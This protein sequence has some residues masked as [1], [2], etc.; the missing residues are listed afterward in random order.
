MTIYL[1]VNLDEAE[2]NA[3]EALRVRKRLSTQQEALREVIRSGLREEQIEEF[4]IT[5]PR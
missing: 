3:L 5:C 2:L 4:D 1:S